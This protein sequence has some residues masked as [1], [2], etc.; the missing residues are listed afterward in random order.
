MLPRTRLFS[1]DDKERLIPA[2]QR[3]RNSWLTYAPFLDSFAAEL[4]RSPDVPPCDVP[5]DVITMNSRAVLLGPREDGAV[6]YTLVYPEDEGVQQGKV[7]VLSLMGMALLGAR[8]GDD[9]SW[10]SSD[11]PEVAKVL[12]LLYQP[13]AASHVHA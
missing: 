9:I 6:C 4:R 3:A 10:H 11:G 5:A 1:A 8:V 13:E 7:S 12:R 2:I